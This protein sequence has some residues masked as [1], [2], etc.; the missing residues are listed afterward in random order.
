MKRMRSAAIAALAMASLT[1]PLVCHG[2][3]GS[4]W[5]VTVKNRIHSVVRVNVGYSNWDSE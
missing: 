2:S 5:H 1:V 3:G 4:T